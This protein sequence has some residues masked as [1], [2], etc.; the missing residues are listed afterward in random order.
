MGVQNSTHK[1]GITQKREQH[2]WNDL[3]QMVLSNSNKLVKLCDKNLKWNGNC[4]P[5]TEKKNIFLDLRYN[6]Q[7]G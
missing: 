2:D 4:I 5:V 1:S 7:W 3:I 6:G